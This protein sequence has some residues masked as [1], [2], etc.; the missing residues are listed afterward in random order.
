MALD[1]SEHQG[2]VFLAKVGRIRSGRCLLEKRPAKQSVGG[3]VGGGRDGEVAD[4]RLKRRG[5]AGCAHVVACAAVK[6]RR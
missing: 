1:E 4:C 2:L 6:M 3:G 5:A